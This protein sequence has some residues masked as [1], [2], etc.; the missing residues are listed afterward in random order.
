MAE[1]SAEVSVGLMN[2]TAR[3][4]PRY[5]LRAGRGASAWSSFC[6]GTV[7]TPPLWTGWDTHAVTLHLVGS[8]PLEAKPC[9]VFIVS[10]GNG[11][12]QVQVAHLYTAVVAI[13]IGVRGRQRRQGR[14]RH[15]CLRLW[16]W[17]RWVAT[18]RRGGAKQ[19]RRRRGRGE[20]RCGDA[21]TRR[22]RGDGVRWMKPRLHGS[23]RC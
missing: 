16:W 14:R 1:A 15:G 17:A 5:M 18:R 22:K 10:S 23:R 21:A 7:L 4:A 13:P 2:W 8:M 11:S 12:H 3:A 9:L 19:Q 6:S 20:M